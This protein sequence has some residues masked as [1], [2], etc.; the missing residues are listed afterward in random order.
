MSFINIGFPATQS[1]ICVI[2]FCL[3]KGK[4]RFS[5][6]VFSCAKLLF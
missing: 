4:D 1:N 3:R 5:W 2:Q 6:L